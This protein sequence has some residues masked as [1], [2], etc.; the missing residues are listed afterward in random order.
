MPYFNFNRTNFFG[1]SLF[2]YNI[3]VFFDTL[4]IIICLFSSYTPFLLRFIFF[5]NYLQLENWAFSLILILNNFLFFNVFISFNF[6]LCFQE[7][8]TKNRESQKESTYFFFSF[9][10][11]IYIFNQNVQYVKWGL[12]DI[13]KK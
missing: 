13:K 5:I 11:N 3:C 9:W 4:S 12:L 7:Q 6:I 10:F 2:D 1:Q 8:F